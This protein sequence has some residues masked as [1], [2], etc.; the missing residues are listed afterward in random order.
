[1]AGPNPAGLSNDKFRAG[2]RLAMQLGTPKDP[3]RRPI[4]ELRTG[5]TS[6]PADDSDVPWDV[7]DSYDAEY[8][9][10]EDVL[11]AVEFSSTRVDERS[12]KQGAVSQGAYLTI[13]ILDEEYALVRDAVAMR[14]SGKRYE[15]DY[16][17]PDLALGDNGVFQL[18]FFAEDI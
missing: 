4:F 12:D 16:D 1:M 5:N 10:V 2:I 13:T 3:A 11:C 6:T 7:D 8:E 15:R 17:R 18:G 14:I 9:D